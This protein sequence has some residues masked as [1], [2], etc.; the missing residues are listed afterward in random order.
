MIIQNTNQTSPVQQP[1]IRVSDN[2][3]KAV[4]ETSLHPAQDIHQQQPSP[5]QLK[6]A[7]DGINQAMRQ[8]NKNLEFSFDSGTNKV[9]IKM[10]DTESGELIRQIPSESALAIARSIDQFQQLQQGLLLDQKA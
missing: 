2:A 5:Q 3:P 4:A 8:S 9:I 1:D 6:T 10:V 7:V